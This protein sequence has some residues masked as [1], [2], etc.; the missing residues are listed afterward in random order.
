MLTL[1]FSLFDF[2]LLVEWSSLLMVLGQFIQIAIFIVCRLECLRSRWAP[3]R[4]ESSSMPSYTVMAPVKDGELEAEEKFIIGGGWAGVWIVVVPLFLVS[5]LMCVLQ[6]W[7]SLVISALLV[8]AMYVLRLI[9][10]G[11]R[12]L[13]GYCMERRA[14]QMSAPLGEG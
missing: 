13:I 10:W 8:L 11:V 2:S 9:D 1:P 14:G 7:E 6:G 4:E 5:A 3:K 12:T